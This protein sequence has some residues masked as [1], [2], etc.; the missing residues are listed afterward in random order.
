MNPYRH[1]TIL[2]LIAACVAVFAGEQARQTSF[3][4]DFGAVPTLIGQSWSEIVHG[5]VSLAAVGEMSHLVTSIFIHGGVDHLLWNM[6][7]LWAFGYV[8]SQVLGQWWVLAAFFICGI[9]GMVLQVWLD[10]GSNISII[11]A[12]GAI[13]GLA[14]LYLGLALRWQLPD[15]DV[16][17]L[18]RPI[19]PLQLGLFAVVG[20]LG[21]V[22]FLS[23][24]AQGIAYGA[25]IG[26]FLSGLAIAAILTTVYPT[27]ASYQHT[28]RR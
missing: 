1:L 10:A 18:A 13:S 4:D 3:A 16:W 17:P 14:G 2:A 19:P 23:N 28:A 5:E 26:G 27:L 11:G 12:S 7:F 20:F 21:D 15:P 22:Y 8:T 6:V 9:C 24:H 25:H